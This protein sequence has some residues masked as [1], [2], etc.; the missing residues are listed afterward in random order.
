MKIFPL[1][2]VGGVKLFPS[3]AIWVGAALDA[4]LGFAVEVASA[5]AGLM[6]VMPGVVSPTVKSLLRL[7]ALVMTIVL[8]PG[9]TV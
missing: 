3:T 5:D 1:N 7:F 2:V 8:P 4:E 6:L 9:E